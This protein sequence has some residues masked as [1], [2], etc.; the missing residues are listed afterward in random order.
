MACLCLRKQA[1]V[2]YQNFV[3]FSLRQTEGDEGVDATQSCQASPTLHEHPHPAAN[4]AWGVPLYTA[5]FGLGIE[6]ETSRFMA[7]RSPTRPCGRCIFI[8]NVCL[9]TPERPKTSKESKFEKSKFWPRQD[10]N[11]GLPSHIRC[12]YHYT[13]GWYSGTSE[14]NI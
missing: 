14:M 10:P 2:E 12:S 11:P 13:T 5:D 7:Q 3:F 9:Y 4:S 6:P 8:P 1:K